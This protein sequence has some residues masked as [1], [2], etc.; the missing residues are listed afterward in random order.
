MD[1]SKKWKD[2]AGNFLALRSDL[3]GNISYSENE[4]RGELFSLHRIFLSNETG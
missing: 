4:I 2:D 1:K 3:N